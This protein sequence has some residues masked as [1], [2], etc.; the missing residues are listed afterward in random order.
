[1]TDATRAWMVTEILPA[2]GQQIDEAETRL[3]GLYL[4]HADAFCAAEK[5]R[6]ALVTEIALGRDYRCAPAPSSTRWS[7]R[8]L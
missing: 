8:T 6:E 2:S 1:M 3:V 4:K 5:C 7:N